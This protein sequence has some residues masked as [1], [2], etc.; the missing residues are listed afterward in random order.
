MHSSVPYPCCNII[1]FAE[2]L[3]DLTENDKF[4]GE[5]CKNL[6]DHVKKIKE[7]YGVKYL[8]L[9]EILVL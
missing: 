6:G 2:R 9:I 8:I 1:R 5:T 3:I 4:R 7:H